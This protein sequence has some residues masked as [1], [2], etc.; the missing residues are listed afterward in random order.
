MS[1]A[2]SSVP[3]TITTLIERANP[4]DAQAM[5]DIFSALY[6]ELRGLARAR[7][8]GNATLTLP[9]TTALPSESYLRLVKPGELEVE[10]RGHFLA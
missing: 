1:D 2:A 7:L 6:P 3:A 9:D 5:N 8:R 10:N 4:G